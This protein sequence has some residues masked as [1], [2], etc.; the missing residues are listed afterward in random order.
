M[1][2]G[3]AQSQVP[4]CSVE[5]MELGLQAHSIQLLKA[6]FCTQLCETWPQPQ[7]PALSTPKPQLLESRLWLAFLLEGLGGILAE[8]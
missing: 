7:R 1:A 5:P 6:E 2:A 3:R 8:H 4:L